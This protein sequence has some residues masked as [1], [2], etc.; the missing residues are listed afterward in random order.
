[1]A[2]RMRVVSDNIADRGTVAAGSVAITAAYLISDEKTEAWRS[3]ASTT[4]TNVSVSWPT[5]ESVSMVAFPLCNFS[6]TA[7]ITV[8]LYSD[9]AGTVLVYTSPSTLCS[10]SAAIKVAGLTLTQSASAYNYLGGTSVVVYFPLRTDVKKVV[11]NIADASNL[12]GYLEAARLVVGAYYTPDHDA[13]VGAT[14]TP[15]DTTT[16]TRSDAGS[17]K[18]EI[19]TKSKNITFDLA[20]MQA[21]D[22]QN[23]WRI[24]SYCG[25]AYPV[26]V[27][28]YPENTDK[29]LEHAYTIYGCFSK[30]S[31]ISAKAFGVFG[32]SLEVDGI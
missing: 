21:S 32:T 25:T 23:I 19:G 22:R 27:S 6:P 9:T 7:A 1:M 28:L 17:L 4:S 26:W 18:R 30:L 31:G 3:V 15:L 8:Q 5:A 20:T 12:Q 14:M 16:T 10:A 24:V 2:N 11:I 13:E 29:N